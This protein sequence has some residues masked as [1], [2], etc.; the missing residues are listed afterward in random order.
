MPPTKP[1]TIAR[2]DA[3]NTAAAMD[4]EL[5]LP[6][7]PADVS[8]AKA[9]AFADMVFGFSASRAAQRNGLSVQQCE[10]VRT[11]HRSELIAAKACRQEIMA[12]MTES[13]VYALVD[14]GLSALTHIDPTQ[15]LTPHALSALANAAQGFARLARELPDRPERLPKSVQHD[16]RAALAELDAIPHVVVDTDPRP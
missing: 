1:T 12:C 9:R 8:P 16:A 6:Y 4:F 10:R 15:P 14:T 13:L 5:L 11:A 2:I 7:L 3:A